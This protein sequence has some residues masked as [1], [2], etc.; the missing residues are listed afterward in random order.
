MR[1]ER[2]QILESYEDFELASLWKYCSQIYFEKI[3][4]L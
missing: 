4:P 3:K 2:L 1:Q